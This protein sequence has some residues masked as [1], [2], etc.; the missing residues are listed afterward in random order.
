MDPVQKKVLALSQPGWG[1]P[2]E[3]GKGRTRTEQRRREERAANTLEYPAVPERCEGSEGPSKLS[4]ALTD[5]GL[6]RGLD[7][8]PHIR[9]SGF[10]SQHYLC[11]LNLSAL[12][13][14][15]A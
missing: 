1:G 13:V 12:Q 10:W 8:G 14:L 7:Q 11:I 15:H 2:L 4:S 6:R 9:L 3:D 5:M